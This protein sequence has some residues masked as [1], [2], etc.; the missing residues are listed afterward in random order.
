[1][2]TRAVRVKVRYVVELPAGALAKSGTVADDYLDILPAETV[3]A[4]ARP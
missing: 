1:M 3:A 4:T 2:A